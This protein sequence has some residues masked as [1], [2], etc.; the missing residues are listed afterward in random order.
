MSYLEGNVKQAI[1]NGEDYPSDAI[2]NLSAA[3]NITFGTS[4]AS[5]FTFL[6]YFFTRNL[7]FQKQ[8]PCLVEV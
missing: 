8:I 7:F 6:S 3:T 4:T 1:V 2:K 5:R